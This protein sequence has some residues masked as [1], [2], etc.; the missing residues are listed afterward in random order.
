MR[1][2]VWDTGIGIP[3]NATQQVFE[4]FHQLGLRGRAR[5]HG[6]G[7]GLAIVKRLSRVLGHRIGVRSQLGKGSVFFVDVPL[8]RL[9]SSLNLAKQAQPVATDSLGSAIALIIEDED[10]VRKGMIALLQSWGCQVVVAA[11]ARSAL[12]AIS[13]SKRSPDIVIADYHLDHGANGLMA[14]EKVREVC[15]PIPALI[16]TADRS[17][18]VLDSVRRQGI[19]A[20]HK[21]LKPAKLRALISHLLSQQRVNAAAE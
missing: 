5:G 15:G 3:K 18:E 2:E 21:P 16:V 14:V 20:L 19:S 11:A 8:G 13:R 17:R 7:L 6:V 9:P 4:E 1:I 10:S 12:R